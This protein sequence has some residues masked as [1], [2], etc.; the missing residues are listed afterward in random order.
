MKSS[1]NYTE[2][3]RQF[4]LPSL[5][6]ASSICAGRSISNLK[7]SRHPQTC[8]NIRRIWLFCIFFQSLHPVILFAV[9]TVHVSRISALSWSS[10]GSRPRLF[11]V[12][13]RWCNEFDGS[14]NPI[15]NQSV[16]F[17]F[18]FI[19]IIK[20]KTQVNSHFRSSV[21]FFVLVLPYSNCP[22]MAG[23]KKN[24][25]LLSSTCG[26]FGWLPHTSGVS[27]PPV[28]FNSTTGVTDLRCHVVRF[29]F[30]FLWLIS[31]IYFFGN[32]KAFYFY[33]SLSTRNVFGI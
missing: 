29:S 24:P 3:S 28:S 20:S 19:I 32:S 10:Q 11:P 4:S 30:L 21:V 1:S 14:L 26:L 16:F 31:F 5:R 12:R 18:F 17:V 23:Q 6:I 15:L 33:C 22:W 9:L 2:N 27:A 7:R 25:Q 8:L 13:T